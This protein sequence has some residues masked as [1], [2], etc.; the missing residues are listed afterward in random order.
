MFYILYTFMAGRKAAEGSEQQR[1]AGRS[2]AGGRSLQWGST[3]LFLGQCFGKGQAGALGTAVQ[4]V[5]D[6]CKGGDTM[7]K[8]YRA[9]E[10][11]VSS[12]WG[13]QHCSSLFTH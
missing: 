5:R 4:G 11:A 9:G 1:P 8:P 2:G 3:G 10:E 13:T 12:C 6:G 7:G